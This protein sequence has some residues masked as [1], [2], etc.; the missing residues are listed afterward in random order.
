MLRRR[1]WTWAGVLVTRRQTAEMWPGRS[2]SPIS[3]AW[4]WAGQLEW[5]GGWVIER[6]TD[7]MWAGGWSMQR[8]WV[9]D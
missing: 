7:G 2:E 8:M 6:L 9:K 3:Q 4:M 1:Q 5:V